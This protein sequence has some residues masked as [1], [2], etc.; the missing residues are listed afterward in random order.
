MGDVRVF[1]PAGVKFKTPKGGTML[2]LNQWRK[3]GLIALGCF[4]F[5]GQYAQATPVLTPGTWVNISPSQLAFGSGPFTQGMAVDPNNP[6]IL[7]LCV[8]GFDITPCG[9]FKTTD[10]GASWRKIGNL[11]EPIRIR[12]DPNNSN[13]L[14]ACDGVR[15]NTEGFWVSNDGGETWTHPQAYSDLTTS[16]LGYFWDMYDIAVDP[17]DFN[18]V[19]GAFHSAW[20]W[21]D[22]KWNTNSGVI[23]SKD[24]GNT[25]IVHDPLSGWGTGHAIT[26]LYNPTLGKG[27]ANTWLLGTQ[28]NGFYRTTDAGTSWAKVTSA[29]IQHGGGAVYYSNTGVLYAS[30][31]D[32]N[33]RSTDNG[34]T[35]TEIG[36]GGGYNCIYGDGTTLY[37]SKGGSTP[38]QVSPESDGINWH[39]FSNQALPG[40][41]FEMALDKDNRIMYAACWTAGIWALKLP[42]TGVKSA[43][44]SGIQPIKQPAAGH[45]YKAMLNDHSGNRSLLNRAGLF[46]ITGRLAR[47]SRGMA[48]GVAII[49]T[50]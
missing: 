23:E 28:G 20:G 22:S 44:S 6:S 48:A 5:P 34:E 24:G 14:Y 38:V 49:K 8:S 26:F 2:Q 12:I 36:D 10:G 37:F 21:T 1:L 30:G 3:I 42:G 41:T 15:G 7:Y 25:W 27:N 47:D 19:L 50:K 11:D 17:T 32:R 16:G 18:H 13:H 40:G 4:L 43:G 46:D 31:S 35:W 45:V 33:Q 29:C 9:M 39:N